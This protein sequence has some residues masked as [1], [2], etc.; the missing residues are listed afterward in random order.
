[1]SAKLLE[2]LGA[3]HSREAAQERRIS[4]RKVV[5]L[6]AKVE[7]PDHTI[8]DGQT[9]DLSSTGVG[10]YSPRQLQADQDCRLT[11]DLSVCGEDL[12]LKLLARV[13]YCTEKA[14]GRFRAGM[15]FIGIEPS[16]AKLLGQLLG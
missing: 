6:R 11:I 2:A 15:R 3:E 4:E 12:E 16:A 8:L 13:C 5:S 9:V 10:L 7:L 1:M 14:K